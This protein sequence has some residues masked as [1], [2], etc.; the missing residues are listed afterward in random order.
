[1]IA[2]HN[3]G[4]E[5]YQKTLFRIAKDFHWNGMK[6]HIRDFICACSICQRHKTET[7]Q[8]IG[9]L[10][11]LPV[12]KHVWFDISLDFVEGLPNSHGKNVILVVVD[13]FSKYCHLLPAAHL[14]SAV[15]IAR[16]SL[17]IFSNYMGYLKEW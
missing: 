9:L 3:Q 14:Y 2:L 5:G 17:R 11:P 6:H 12:P 7:L 16:L 13:R 4:H 1:M 8:S 15:S 10:Q